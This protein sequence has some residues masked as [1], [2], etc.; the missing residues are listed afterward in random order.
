[1][2]VVPL[3]VPI[4]TLTRSESTSEESGL[5]IEI[6]HALG[7]S[8]SE[9]QDRCFRSDSES[10]EVEQVLAEERD[11]LQEDLQERERF[12]ENM[13]RGCGVELG[14]YREDHMF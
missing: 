7:E 12:D 4:G 6:S 1:M 3:V 14:S 2:E 5:A 9:I 8:L 11:L 13:R 10:K